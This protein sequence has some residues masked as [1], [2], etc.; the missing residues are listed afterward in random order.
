MEIRDLHNFIQVVDHDSFTKAAEEMYVTQSSLSKSIKRLEKQL[1]SELLDRKSK[2]VKLTDIGM[3]VYQ[4]GKEILYAIDD[5]QLLIKKSKNIEVGRLKLGMPPLI[6][7][8]FFPEIAETFNDKF[9]NIKI[10]LFER[11]AKKLEEIVL[12]GKVEI[13][14]VVSPYFKNN[15][16]DIYPF[17]EDEFFVFLHKD[18]VLASKAEISINELRDEKFIIFTEEFTLHDY[19]INA[20]K[21]AGFSP[22]VVYKSSQWDLILEL[23][24]SSNGVTLLPRSIY[25]KNLNPNIKLIKIKGEP[26]LWKLSFIT[27]KDSYKSFV[28]EK[29][30]SLIKK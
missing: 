23:T 5:L 17:I 28:L 29:F 22:E 11:G 27:L 3:L 6:G 26:L 21:E 13:A 10:E 8:L 15:M 1:T 4:Q 2:K 19:V 16:Y 25:K 9:P 18:H 20:C 24:V 12:D 7:T 30:I 14:L